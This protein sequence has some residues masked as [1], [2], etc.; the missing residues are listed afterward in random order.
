M[1]LQ[2]NFFNTANLNLFWFYSSTFSWYSL[3]DLGTC[4]LMET[5]SRHGGVGVG[6]HYHDYKDLYHS[7]LHSGVVVLNLF[8]KSITSWSHFAKKKIL[9]SHAV[10]LLC[11]FFYKLPCCVSEAVVLIYFTN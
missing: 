5:F 11:S 6:E 2:L 7:F 9:F 3:A 10:E 8:Y 4:L 1:Y